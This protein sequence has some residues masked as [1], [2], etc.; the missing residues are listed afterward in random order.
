M[1]VD[2]KRKIEKSSLVIPQTPLFLLQ[3]FTS[4]AWLNCFVNLMPLYEHKNVKSYLTDDLTDDRIQY[5]L[6]NV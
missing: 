4:I 2:C 3:K 1:Y 5:I 6:A